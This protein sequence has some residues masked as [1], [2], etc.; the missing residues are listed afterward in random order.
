MERNRF[1]EA[2]KE[3]DILEP[4]EGAVGA[5]AIVG[6]VM[7]SLGKG[8]EKGEDWEERSERMRVGLLYLRWLIDNGKPPLS[9]SRRREC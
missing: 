1:D 3:V 8:K 2:L 6:S 4:E 5:G 7:N 9:C